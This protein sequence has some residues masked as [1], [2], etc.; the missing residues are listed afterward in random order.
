MSSFFLCAGALGEEP[1]LASLVLEAFER[2]FRDAHDAA[3]YTTDYS[4]NWSDSVGVVLPHLCHGF[5]NLRPLS[6][7]GVVKSK[8]LPRAKE[9]KSIHTPRKKVNG[10]G[11]Q[12]L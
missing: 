10:V 5:G 12:D 6:A 3:H 11:S 8:T 7:I 4:T 2:V 9:L 1:R